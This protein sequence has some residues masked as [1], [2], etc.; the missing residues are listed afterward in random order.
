MAI[1]VGLAAIVAG[2]FVSLDIRPAWPPG[3]RGSEVGYPRRGSE[4][5][6]EAGVRPTPGTLQ[7]DERVMVDGLEWSL[8]SYESPHGPCLDVWVAD[9]TGQIVG[10]QGGCGTAEP[11]RLSLGGIEVDGR[12]YD[13]HYGEAAPGATRV[14][15]TMEDGSWNSIQV[16]AGVWLF[17][18]AGDPQVSVSRIEL[19]DTAGRVLADASPPSLAAL[20]A[21]AAEA[22]AH[23]GE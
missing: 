4:P 21:Q 1:V 20:R 14:I 7:V 2:M 17:V 16:K 15:L 9:G 10:P 11:F 3:S 13:V 8:V 12:R 5:R 18:A 19:V 22:L 6:L 23:R